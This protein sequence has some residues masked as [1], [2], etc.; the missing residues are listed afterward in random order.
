MNLKEILEILYSRMF[1]PQTQDSFNSY[2]SLLGELTQKLPVI[3]PLGAL[4]PCRSIEFENFFIEQLEGWLSQ[5]KPH[6]V[7]RFTLSET[8]TLIISFQSHFI[9]LFSYLVD[10]PEKL[11][12]KN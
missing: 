12:L 4:M 5:A 10:Q 8:S 7:D 1:H 11:I 6:L 3:D 9:D 2:L